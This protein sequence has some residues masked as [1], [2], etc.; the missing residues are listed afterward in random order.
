MKQKEVHYIAIL[1]TYVLDPMC[2][3]YN[4]TPGGDLN[5]QLQG[6]LSP[7]SKN[8]DAQRFEIIYLLKN[9]DMFMKDIAKYVGLNSKDGEKL[10]SMINNGENFY[11]P[12]ETYPLRKRSVTRMGGLNPAAKEEAAKE[13]VELLITTNYSQQTIANMCGVHY[14]TVSDI[15]RCKKWTNLHHYKT[16]IRNE[17][18]EEKSKEVI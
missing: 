18:K 14:N 13:V 2:C 17:V 9:T 11:Q 16:N 12:N 6:E 4:M 3:G 10:V 1:H 15:N 8:S 5:N 7:V